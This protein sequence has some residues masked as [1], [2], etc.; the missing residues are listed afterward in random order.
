M[1]HRIANSVFVDSVLSIQAISRRNQET[2]RSS[3]QRSTGVTKIGNRAREC[4]GRAR[5]RAS[6]TPIMPR[7][8]SRHVTAFLFLT[9]ARENIGAWH[10]QSHADVFPATC[11]TRRDRGMQFCAT[12]FFFTGVLCRNAIS[13]TT[14]KFIASFETRRCTSVRYFGEWEK[15]FDRAIEHPRRRFNW[16]ARFN[17]SLICILCIC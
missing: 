14:R 13:R 15:C 1:H 6:E 3:S 7:R 17:E 9:R 8:S 10:F 12:R 5:G 4:K 11:E 2:S 16:Y